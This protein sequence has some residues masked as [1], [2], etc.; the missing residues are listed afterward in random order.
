MLQY[1][2]ICGSHILSLA[3]SLIHLERCFGY[4]PQ[5]ERLPRY[6]QIIFDIPT[7]VCTE[8][9][10]QHALEMS[11]LPLF[12]ITHNLRGFCCSSCG[13]HFLSVESRFWSLLR[14][15]GLVHSY[16]LAHLSV[17]LSRGSDDISQ[18]RTPH[19]PPGGHGQQNLPRQWSRCCQPRAHNHLHLHKNVDRSIVWWVIIVTIF[20]YDEW[21]IGHTDPHEISHH[22]CWNWTFNFMVREVTSSGFL[23][24]ASCR[25]WG[26]AKGLHNNFSKSMHRLIRSRVQKGDVV[27]ATLEI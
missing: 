27:Q 11:F 16:R 14:I 23:R 9:A 8:P 1:S 22:C 2:A 19:P 17:F 4:F 20:V 13:N 5:Y 26:A 18:Q 24:H 15:L 12:L 3:G 21:W 6:K 7:W 25:F 10:H